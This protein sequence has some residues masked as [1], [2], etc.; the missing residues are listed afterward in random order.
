VRP[1]AVRS[2]VCR[3]GRPGEELQR[4]SLLC[5]QRCARGWH[6]AQ[7]WWHGLVESESE[8]LQVND[9]LEMHGSWYGTCRTPRGS[10]DTHGTHGRTRASHKRTSQPSEPTNTPDSADEHRIRGL[11]GTRFPAYFLIWTKFW[12]EWIQAPRKRIRLALHV[13]AQN[14]SQTTSQTPK[15]PVRYMYDAGGAGTHTGHTGAHGHTDHTDARNH[16]NP[17]T[18]P[19]ARRAPNPRPTGRLNSR[20]PRKMPVPVQKHRGEPELVRVPVQ[21]RAESAGNQHAL[22]RSRCVFPYF[23]IWSFGRFVLELFWKEGGSSEGQNAKA[24]T[25]IKGCQCTTGHGSGHGR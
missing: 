22:R 19:T 5:G 2:A 4:P 13:H 18:H 15:M 10:R 25:A 17:P 3:W 24:T 23:L 16:P 8:L 7:W 14:L 20:N 12:K 9:M 21:S 6:Q 1:S 11:L